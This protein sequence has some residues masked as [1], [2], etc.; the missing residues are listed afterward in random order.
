MPGGACEA[1]A[2]ASFGYSSTCLCLPLG[3]YHNMERIDEVVAGERPAKVGRE[4]IG[5][6]DYHGLIEMLEVVASG[7][8]SKDG[9]ID[10]PSRLEKL[11]KRHLNVL[12]R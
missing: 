12:E 10:L 2:F 3:N 7:L 5:L 8:D 9:R 4:Y 1:T 6:D 11:R